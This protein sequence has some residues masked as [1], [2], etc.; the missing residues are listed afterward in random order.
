LRSRK[1]PQCQPAVNPLRLTAHVRP[2]GLDR[3]PKRSDEFLN[4]ELFRS[5]A[6]TVQTR[7]GLATL[8]AVGL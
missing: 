4:G 7:Y 6:K 3:N 8:L 2:V 5:M 1:R